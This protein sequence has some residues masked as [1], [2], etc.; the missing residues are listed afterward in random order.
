MLAV[1][2]RFEQFDQCA[3]RH[4][5]PG[6]FRNNLLSEVNFREPLHSVPK[7]AQVP[8]QG[9]DAAWRFAGNGIEFKRFNAEQ[10]VLLP[11]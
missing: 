9:K 3:V 2:L 1:K 6:D 7:A 4:A 10:G 8:F 11:L 5:A